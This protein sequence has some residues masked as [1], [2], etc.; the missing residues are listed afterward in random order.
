MSEHCFYATETYGVEVF[1]DDGRSK[2]ITVP[3]FNPQ[4]SSLLG[5]SFDTEAKS[6]AL[7]HCLICGLKPVSA[8]IIDRPDVQ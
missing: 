3:A 1:L 7:E 6:M 5:A 4:T 8:K 2:Y